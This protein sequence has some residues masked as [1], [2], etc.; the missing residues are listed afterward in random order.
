ME[1]V[2]QNIYRWTGKREL[3]DEDRAYADK[4]EATAKKFFG[5]KKHSRK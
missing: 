5:V 4:L 1:H 3:T 2:T